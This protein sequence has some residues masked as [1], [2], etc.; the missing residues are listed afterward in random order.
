[1]KFKT[2]LF[3]NL[4]WLSTSYAKSQSFWITYPEIEKSQPGIYHFRK[5]FT[6]NAIPKS[7]LINVAASTNYRLYIN[8]IPLSPVQIQ[9]TSAD[10]ET[11]N[12][13]QFLMQGENSLAAIVWNTSQPVFGVQGKGDL[14]KIVNTDTSWKV[15]ENKAYSLIGGDEQLNA[16]LYPWNWEETAYKDNIWQHAVS[17]TSWDTL[18]EH[19]NAAINEEHLQRFEMLNSDPG[20]KTS[21][22]FIKGN[23]P[24]KIPANGSFTLLL[25]T[26][27]GGTE[28]PELIVSEGKGSTIKMIR[29]STTSPQENENSD[30]FIAD[31][32][33]NRK[34]RPLSTKN[35]RYLQ[36]Q[37]ATKDQPLILNDVYSMSSG[38]KL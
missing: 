31:G 15:I 16:G 21:T 37:I 19:Q 28:Y 3:I 34:F 22:G 32:G 13:A 5:N 2:L 18:P 11:I 7:F 27:A 6:L 35:Y 20:L 24:L 25:E 10:Y 9:A 29:K 33:D 36:L 1:M 38:I 14:E 8:G 23:K 17:K 30:I 26:T 4:L 12:I